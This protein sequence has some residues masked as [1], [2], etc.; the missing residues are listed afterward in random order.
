MAILNDYASESGFL[1]GEAEGQAMLLKAMQA[2][3]I[4]G[5]DTNNLALTQE[6]LK[7]ESLENT[8]KLLESRATDFKLLNSFPKLT[9]YNTV[10]EFNQLVSYGAQRGGFYNE[11]ELSDVEDSTYTRRSVNIKYLQVTGEVTMQ[12][13]MV[14]SY[15]DAYQQEVKNKMMWI[16][17]LANKTLAIG[18]SNVVPQQFDGIFKLHQSVGSGNG[19]LYASMSDYYNSDNVKDLR[20]ASL[21]QSDIEDGAVTVDAHFGSVDTLFAP[22]TIISAFSKD[23]YKAQRIMLNGNS[24][25]DGTVGTTPK[26]VST[27]FGDIKL[28]TDKSLSRGASKNTNTP[29]DSGKV[30]A[31]PASVTAALVTETASKYV[32]G[33]AGTAFY[34]VAAVN[35]SG[36]SALTAY[37]TGLVGAAGKSV[38]ITITPGNNGIAATGYV[39]NRTVTGLA[40][41]TGSDFYPIFKI[42]AADLAAGYDGAVA[43]TVRDRGYFLP[44]CED[45]F[46]TEMSD[47]V[48]AIKQLAP[49]SK[50]D[51]AVISMSRRFIVFNFLAL[52]CYSP[53]K[54]V[55][56]INVGKKYTAD[57]TV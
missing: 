21:K 33:D 41:A 57:P 7:I 8:V 46:V 45:A 19:F 43:G 25:F 53:R 30:P 20:G 54:I 31:A 27:T 35:R 5:R 9:A 50:L 42:S 29:S 12:A 11:G 14:K 39:I 18:D 32:A 3:S 13:Q 2:G 37:G 40:S 28:M 51:L 26:A 52:A 47:E 16:S 36:E 4:T 22:P 56:Y 10:E 55:R 34:A 17:R 48:L 49:I 6:P 1:G 44:N 24:G 38:D 23:Y 15:L